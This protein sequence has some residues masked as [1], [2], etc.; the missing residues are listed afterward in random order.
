MKRYDVISLVKETPGVHGKF[1]E[2][3]EST[4]QVYCEIKSVTRNEVYQAMAI[5]KNA[6]IVFVL[7][8]ADDYEGEKIVVYKDVRYRVI[9]TYISDD[10]IELTCEVLNE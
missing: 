3:E 6:S 5:G 4:R 9:R 2:A 1:E 7:T 10:G 8:L